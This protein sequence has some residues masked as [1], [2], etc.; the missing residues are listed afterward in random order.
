MLGASWAVKKVPLAQQ[1]LVSV[2]DHAARSVKH[3]EILLNRLRVV[4]AVWLARLHDLYVHPDV[5]PVCVLGLNPQDRSPLR[6]TERRSISEVRDQE[7]VHLD[8]KSTRLNSSHANISYA[9][10]CL[11]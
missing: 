7:S 3:K 10:F 5:R 1:M 8:R 11:K 2:Q 6:V 9:V 4:L